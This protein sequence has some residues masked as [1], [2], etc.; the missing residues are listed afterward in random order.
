MARRL[1]DIDLAVGAG[2]KPA[3]YDNSEEAQQKETHGRGNS[4]K[5]NGPEKKEHG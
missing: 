3:L 5:K 4:E 1:M 2:L